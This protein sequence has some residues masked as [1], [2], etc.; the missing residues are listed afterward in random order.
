MEI[1][2]STGEIESV[3]PPLSLENVQTGVQVTARAKAAQLVSES[4]DAAAD[5]GSDLQLQV[6]LVSKND[7]VYM[8]TVY[9]GTPVSQPAHVVFDTGSEYLTITSALCDDA[10]AGN[11][12]FKKW[13][14]V[15][16]AFTPRGPP[17]KRCK[18]MAYD[19]H[20]SKT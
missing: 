3:E 15:S 18:T 2:S 16:K 10:A 17:A 9:M 20:K 13:D 7:A 5:K 1:Q 12:H 4:G 6:P 11:F 14:P 19:M 8:G